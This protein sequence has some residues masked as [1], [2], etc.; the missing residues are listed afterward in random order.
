MWPSLVAR[1]EHCNGADPDSLAD[2]AGLVVETGTSG[3]QR[4]VLWNYNV[5]G[6]N[7]A[8]TSASVK[9]SDGSAY[10]EMIGGNFMLTRQIPANL[11]IGYNFNSGIHMPPIPYPS[12]SEL[13][14][15]NLRQR[16]AFNRKSKWH[17]F[18]FRSKRPVGRTKREC[19]GLRPPPTV[20]LKGLHDCA[21]RKAN[22]AMVMTVASSSHPNNSCAARA[23]CTR[24]RVP[25]RL[26]DANQR[27][28]QRHARVLP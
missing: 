15:H 25:F 23:P 6:A 5:G 12:Q 22:A 28:N 19:R 11:H 27:C 7:Y 24:R 21:C 10:W 17:K 16:R 20:Q 9:T 14:L 1:S 4:S 2:K 26:P 8:P 3:F 18:N 13:P